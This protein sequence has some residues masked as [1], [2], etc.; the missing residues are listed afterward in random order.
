MKSQPKRNY[1]VTEPRQRCNPGLQKQQC[2]GVDARMRSGQIPRRHE[3]QS[4]RTSS[5][6]RQG[7]DTAVPSGGPRHV[8]FISALCPLYVRSMSAPSSLYI[9]LGG[10]R[11][12]CWAAVGMWTQRCASCSS[13]LVSPVRSLPNRTAT[14]PRAA[15]AQGFRVVCGLPIMLATALAH[16]TSTPR[17]ARPHATAG[18]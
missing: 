9:R 18:G 7:Q 15:C 2:G 16:N 6:S 13:S 1:V 10:G 8:H 14:R 4:S 5:C 17:S 3:R 12:G 11:T